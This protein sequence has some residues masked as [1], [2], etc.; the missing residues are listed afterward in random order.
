MEMATNCLNEERI[1]ALADGEGDAADRAHAAACAACGARLRDRA[2]L[3]ASIEATLNPPVGLP[4]EFR[5]K[6]TSGATR[7]RSI[8][9]E[10]RQAE[11]SRRWIYTAAALAAA[12]AGVLFI[13]PAVR[14][15]DATV[16]ASEILAKSATRLSAVTRGVE[17]LEYEL[18]LGGVP[19][20]MIP[21]Q[22]DGTYRIWQA[23]DHDVPGRFRFASYAADGRMFS[24]IAED[25]IAKRR[26]TAFT[27]EGQAYRFDVTLPA[28]PR[29]LSLPEIQRLH[30]EATI[31]M[32]QASGNTLVETIAGPNGP[33]YR[34]EV[35][36]VT[37]P[38]TNPV[39][40]LTEARVVIDPRDYSVVE[41]A[42]QGSL[43]KSPYSMSY[44][45]LRH[46]VGATLQPDAFS[47]PPQA[48]EIV[49]TGEGSAVAAHDV[50]VLALRALAQA[51]QAR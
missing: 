7:L 24:S 32:M 5:L 4:S 13:V 45:L 18:V 15:S 25:P 48:G 9:G 43:L 6:D 3:M 21:D 37:A 39:W 16:S 8:S 26:V 44:K 31:A 11:G 50:V 17:V 30:M 33:L 20:E 46:V 23:I 12:L 41:C 34:I 19:K 49:V 36:R 51:K 22:V 2:A 35:P 28:G 27:S 10:S 47:V 38:G 42:V 1:Q 14:K 40:D 29:N